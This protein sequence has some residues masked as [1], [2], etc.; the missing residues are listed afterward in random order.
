MG[1]FIKIID[2]NERVHYLNVN[3]IIS[4]KPTSEILAGNTIIKTTTEEI[5]TSTTPEEVMDMIN[6]LSE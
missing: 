3:Y 4:F 1:G 6:L 2:T 5:Q